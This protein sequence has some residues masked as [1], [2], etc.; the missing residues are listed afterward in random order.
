[1]STKVSSKMEKKEGKGVLDQRKVI[2][3]AKNAKYRPADQ[4]DG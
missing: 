2:K 4:Y 3:V 1:M